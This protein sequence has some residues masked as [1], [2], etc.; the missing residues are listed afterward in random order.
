MK[1]NRINVNCAHCGENKEITQYRYNRNE[2]HYCNS[3]CYWA[4]MKHNNKGKNNN[5]W[6]SLDVICDVCGNIYS[7]PPSLINE[8]NLCK[9]ECIKKWAREQFLG[10]KNC[11]W[12]GIGKFASYDH[13]YDKISFAEVC[14]RYPENKNIL[15]VK[16][17]YCNQWFSPTGSEVSGRLRC[18]NGKQKGEL[19]LY[20][21][22]GCRRSC[23]IYRQKNYPKGF[24]QATSREVQPE[25]RKMV[26]ERDEWQCIKCGIGVEGKLHCHHLE[27]VEVNPLMSADLENCITLC[28]AHHLEAHK[29]KDCKYHDLRRKAC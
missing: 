16:C 25:L 12:K 27:G 6:K 11:K 3:K 13:Y 19:R 4:W 14:R 18:L 5:N 29:Q 26:L 9:E 22:D 8:H 28:K 24:K 15:Q 1:K 10:E 21:S 20:C 2:R 23:N 17:T 7:K